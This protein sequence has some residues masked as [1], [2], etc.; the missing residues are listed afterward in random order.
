M[1]VMTFSFGFCGRPVGSVTPGVYS[2]TIAPSPRL[3]RPPAPLINTACFELTTLR[4]WAGPMMPGLRQA[5][6]EL[7]EIRHPESLNHGVSIRASPCG[8]FAA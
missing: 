4:H 3:D 6:P 8:D 5:E 7:L 1:G 2:E